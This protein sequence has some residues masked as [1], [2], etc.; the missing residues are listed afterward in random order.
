[1]NR[2]ITVIVESLAGGA[3]PG[4][5]GAINPK[6]DVMPSVDPGEEQIDA[7]RGSVTAH[8]ETVPLLLNLRGNR[9]KR[10][11]VFGQL[12]AHGWHCMFGL[13][14]D[15]HLKQAEAVMRILRDA[16]DEGREPN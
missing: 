1:V 12:D 7:F 10:H 16:Q 5:L 6:T 11:P 8:L 9:T 13:H 15:I 14:L 3:E 4:G 2:S